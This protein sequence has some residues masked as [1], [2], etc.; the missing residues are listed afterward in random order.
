[1]EKLKT[2]WYCGRLGSA[3]SGVLKNNINHR[4]FHNDC[5]KSYEE[6][7][8]KRLEQYVE[9]KILVMHERALRI[10]EK[11][12]TNLELYYD[13]SIAVCEKAIEEPNKFLSS[14]EMV[15]A[16]ELLRNEVRFK[17]EHKILNHRVDFLIPEYNVVLEIDGHTHK[18]NKVAD[19]KRD[20]NILN[21]LNKDGNGWEVIRIP[22]KRIEQNVQ[23]LLP[24]IVSIRNYKQELR[25][26]NNGL[27]PSNYSTRDKA[28]YEETLSK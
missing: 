7:R 12:D 10:L 5:L 2:C 16:M 28:Y 25:R 17:K 18:Y 23:K 13:E 15:A 14:H 21:E 8:D 3:R 4:Y 6:E 1:M 9:L 20:A 11:Q 19:T 27:I 22:T 24:A 26:K